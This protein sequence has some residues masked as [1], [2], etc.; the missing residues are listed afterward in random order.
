MAKTRRNSIENM[1]A[2]KGSVQPQKK[3]I[4]KEEVQIQEPEE[5]KEEAVV[6]NEIVKTEEPTI[7]VEEE[8]I[9]ES[10]EI[11][12]KEEVKEPAPSNIDTL[13]NKQKKKKRGHQ[14]T[15]YFKK[16]VYD[17]CNEIAE[18][19]EIGMSDVVNKL[20]SSIMEEE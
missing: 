3:E 5:T 8:I 9:E 16:D 19:Y 7:E 4:V 20:I 12:P 1:F 14:Q 15:I 13:F 2:K 10:K 17:F 18:R 11:L 6:V